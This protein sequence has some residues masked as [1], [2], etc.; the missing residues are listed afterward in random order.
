MAQVLRSAG[1]HLQAPVYYLSHAPLEAWGLPSRTGSL[2]ETAWRIRA[3]TL[4]TFI[5]ISLLC[6]L[7]LTSIV[8]KFV[9]NQLDGTGYEEARGLA[10]PTSGPVRSILSYNVCMFPGGLPLLMGGPEPAFDRFDELNSFIREQDPDLICLQELPAHTARPLVSLLQDHYPHFYFNG[11]TSSALMDAG[12]FIASKKTPSGPVQFVEFTE[13]KFGMHRGFF[14]IPFD[15]KV[16]VT[17]H[18]EAGETATEKAIRQAEL[19]QINTHMNTH[20]QGRPLVLCG[21]LNILR[22]VDGAHNEYRREMFSNLNLRPVETRTPTHNEN[23]NAQRLGQRIPSPPIQL[24]Y[25]A[26]RGLTPCRV[27]VIPSPLSDHLP[28]AATF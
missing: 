21:D 7:G 14:I 19:S 17:T 8:C 13:R 22:R 26:T 25:F 18:M 9:A 10:E 24:D 3:M 16:V 2:W 12:L 23:H 6:T 11:S 4:D 15:D 20:Y 1:H 5:L 28:I 27:S